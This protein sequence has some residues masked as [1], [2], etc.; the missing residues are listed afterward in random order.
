M[1][2]RDHGR[3]FRPL[4]AWF[5]GFACLGAAAA[6]SSAP[7]A[8]PESK[9]VS[10]PASQPTRAVREA[11]LAA[12]F[13]AGNAI[14]AGFDR[15]S[16]DAPW[17]LGD[18]VLFGLS[19]EHDAEVF[20]RFVELELRSEVVPEGGTA[21]GEA[22][23]GADPAVRPFSLKPDR[24]PVT[25][26]AVDEK[27]TI[28]P[29]PWVVAAATVY[30]AAGERLETELIALPEA[31]LRRG[32]HEAASRATAVRRDTRRRMNGVAEGT[33]EY[34][35]AIRMDQ[36]RL[37]DPLSDVVGATFGFLEIFKSSPA[38][39]SLRSRAVAEV[40]ETPG[41]FSVV[42]GAGVAG[43]VEVNID[44]IFSSERRMPADAAESASLVMP[45]DFYLN[46]EP[47]LK[48]RLYVKPTASPLHLAAGVASLEA[49]HPKKP[50]RRLDVRLLAARRGPPSA[51]DR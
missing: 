39:E 15:A 19:L 14:L 31:A 49:S 9:P 35:E 43:R 11:A 37:V 44:A 51:G 42:F 50:G 38:L 25:F 32:F 48:C 22:R 16:T 7:P 17:R 24:E 23:Y 27:R 13:A 6:C 45:L 21:V 47:A 1:A 36:E 3:R 41:F 26:H 5:G 2:H 28:A 30:G 46:D 8:E 40:V 33:P 18:R 10:R 29:G 12:R 4:L 34:R 20:V